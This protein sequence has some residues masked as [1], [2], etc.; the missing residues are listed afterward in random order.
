MTAAR[1]VCIFV[2]GSLACGCG[3]GPFNVRDRDP[4]SKIPGIKQAVQD[5]D[6]SAAKYLV[7]DLDSDDPAVRFYAIE[8]LQRLT[9]QDFGYKYYD[10]EVARQPAMLKWRD[11]LKE[12]ER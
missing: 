9:G 2:G 6:L 11:W 10:D 12:Q 1:W 7:A 5:K 3:P 8:G 4:A